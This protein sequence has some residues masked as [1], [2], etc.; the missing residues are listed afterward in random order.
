MAHGAHDDV[1]RPSMT[2]AAKTRS[3]RDPGASA[4]LLVSL[5]LATLGTGWVS[6][7]C[8][9]AL[10]QT[11]DI[12]IVGVPSLGGEAEM[13][14]RVLPDIKADLQR[15][16]GWELRS[17]PRVY[18]TSDPKLFEKMTGSRFISAFAVP[19]EFLVAM[20][21]DVPRS[22]PA[23]M[24]GILTHEL[25]HLLLHENIEDALLPKWL[26]EGV[27]Q[28]VSGSLG[29]ILSGAA[30]NR[31]D[32][33]LAGRAIPLGELSSRFPTDGDGLLLA[34]AVSRSFVE[35]LVAR[36]GVE[37][38]QGVLHR[39]KE[40]SPVEIAVAATLSSSLDQLEQEWLE[41]LGGGA[42][43]LSWFSRHFYDLLFFAMALLAAAGAMRLLVKRR[44]RLAEMEEEE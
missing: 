10:I 41:T 1:V 21:V 11:A 25:C 40:G 33:D 28:W 12:E 27:C 2:A 31:I 20:L 32:L 30:V 19:A 8:G 44:S 42:A 43:W 5:V 17:R 9:A 26:D 36:F 29:E 38:L 22:N 18:L 6:W 39:L 16:T 23:L 24:R 7:A 34:Y 3:K 4:R 15:A 13:L 14:L 35:Y 37:G